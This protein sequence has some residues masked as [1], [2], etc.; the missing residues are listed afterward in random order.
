MEDENT[1]PHFLS[2]FEIHLGNC[3][4][5]KTIDKYTTTDQPPPQIKTTLN[6]AIHH[7]NIIGWENLL[8]GYTSSF[9]SR[10]QHQIPQNEISKSKRAP[11]NTIL[12][13][14]ALELHK[15][16]WEDRNIFVNG[17]T[18]KES[19]QKLRQRTLE[20][21]KSIYHDNP[22]LASRYSAIK[23][24]LLEQRLRRTTKNLLDCIVKITHQMAIT[25]YIED[26]NVASQITISEAFRR[27]KE[28]QGGINK[29]PP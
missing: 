23:E 10:I 7:Q 11:W 12:I 18:I 13:R 2:C 24:V 4:T 5:V 26:T 20:R 6:D 8:R 19:H 9:W 22:K 21:V 29:Y 1:A 25:K 15:N 14:K 17:K 16:I 27:A 3:L 28:Q